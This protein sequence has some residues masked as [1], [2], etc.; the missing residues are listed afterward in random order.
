M[1]VNYQP[2]GK[3][4]MVYLGCPHATLYEVKE[5]SRLLEGK[6]VAR[7]TR[8]FV[9]TAHS[10][11]ASAERLGY[12]Q[13]IEESGGELLADGCLLTYYVYIDA[14]KPNME[15]VATDSLKHAFGVRRS[16]KSNVFFGDT[17]RCIEIAVEGGV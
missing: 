14:K 6:H 8:L 2:E 4:N 10:I 5:I 1:K 12:A 13:I 3:V 17:K 16:F 7:G 11:R 15:R 9:Q